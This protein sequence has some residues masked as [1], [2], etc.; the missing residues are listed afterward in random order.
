MRAAGC[1][2]GVGVTK[3]L[4]EALAVLLVA[5]EPRS[6]GERWR[7]VI[8]TTT[9]ATSS[10]ANAAVTFLTMGFIGRFPLPHPRGYMGRRGSGAYLRLRDYPRSRLAGYCSMSWAAIRQFGQ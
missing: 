3:G 5:A 10:N 2:L 8:A 1:P 9:M 6:A 7:T 4:A